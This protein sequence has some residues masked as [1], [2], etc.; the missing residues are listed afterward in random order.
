[1]VALPGRLP[2]DLN[3]ILKFLTNFAAELSIPLI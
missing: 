2:F 3:Q 1:M